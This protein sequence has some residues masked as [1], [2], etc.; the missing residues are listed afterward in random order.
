MTTYRYEFLDRTTQLVL[1]TDQDGNTVMFT[2][3]FEMTTI[4]LLFAD[5]WNSQASYSTFCCRVETVLQL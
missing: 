1:E 5:L 3:T 4:L 2:V